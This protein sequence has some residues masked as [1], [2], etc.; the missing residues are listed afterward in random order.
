M[1]VKSTRL[2]K[3]TATNFALIGSFAGVRSHVQ[4]DGVMVVEL[5]EADFAS[6][7]CIRMS[8]GPGFILYLREYHF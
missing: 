2:R 8:F 1:S 6:K 3:S 5:F 4:L 7:T